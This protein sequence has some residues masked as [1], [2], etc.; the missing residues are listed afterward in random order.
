[1]SVD[2]A[3]TLEDLSLGL[4]LNTSIGEEPK[5]HLLNQALCA[6]NRG[7]NSASIG[8][9]AE[10]MLCDF[11]EAL[12]EEDSLTMR[13]NYPIH[14]DGS[15]HGD[16]LAID[17]GGSTLRVAVVSLLPPESSFELDRSH[18][19]NI[20]TMKLWHVDDSNK[21]LNK[22]FFSWVAAKI[23]EVLQSQQK[24]SSKSVIKTGITWSFP[25]Q[26]VL[27]NSANV[28]FAGKGYKIMPEVYGHDLKVLIEEPLASEYNIKL[29]VRLIMNDSL[30]VYAAG[31]FID[32]HT[33]LALVL[34]TGVNM[35]CI[36]PASEKM[37][38]SKHGFG[39]NVLFNTELSLY[40]GNLLEDVAT[41]Y[42]VAVDRHFQLPL[43]FKPHMQYDPVDNSL[44]QPAELLTSGRYLPELVRLALVDCIEQDGLFGSILGKKP[45]VAQ[46][47]SPYE[48]FAGELMCLI[49]ESDDNSEICQAISE[50]FGWSAADIDLNDVVA[51]KLLVDAVIRRAA[52]V[53]STSIVSLIK[54][55]VQHNGSLDTNLVNIAYVGSVLQYFTRYRQLIINFVNQCQDMVAMGVKIDLILVDE[56]SIVGAAIGAAHYSQ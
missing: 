1:M 21:V 26:T 3:K 28:C 41:K 50:R 23:M 47:M 44:F 38:K 27:F 8:T 36:L 11:N 2:F 14:S 24:L 9:R 40:G 46:L 33:K 51:L 12:M 37:H 53:V 20:T 32:K 34:G 16:F 7:V 30:A 39:K 19:V 4:T 45:A 52:F 22:E 6:F 5:H 13:P 43:T 18:R 48:G 29:D 15:E 42:D 31:T 25:L 55:I 56:S 35:C 10:E 54:L 49:S 17:L